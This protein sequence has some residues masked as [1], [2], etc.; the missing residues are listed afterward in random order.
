MRLVR[1]AIILLWLVIAAGVSSNVYSADQDAIRTRI[2]LKLFRAIL[3]ADTQI[4][5]KQ[6]ADGK[7]ALAIIYKDDKAQ[8]DIYAAM[9]QNLGKG[10]KQGKVKGIP[11]TVQVITVAQLTGQRYAGIY[12]VET[13]ASSRL[14]QLVDYGIAQKIISY[15]PF[16]DAVEQGIS[17]GLIIEARTKPYVNIQTLQRSQLQIKSFF[18]KVSKH[19][20]P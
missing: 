13:F 15:S 2:G 18:L 8:A 12:L 3:A 7:L 5:T 14:Q 11:I 4:N 9:L 19:Y 1:H 17:A 6:G 20:E 16:V 10:V